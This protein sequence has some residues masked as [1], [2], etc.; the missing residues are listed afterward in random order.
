MQAPRERRAQRAEGERS[1]P[2]R[3]RR[4]RA[5][6]VAA[7][8]LVAWA[9]V[10]PPPAVAPTPPAQLPEPLR[11]L[12]HNHAPEELLV[13]ERPGSREF[14]VSLHAA[15][16]AVN[17]DRGPDRAP[18]ALTVLRWRRDRSALAGI[19]PGATPVERVPVDVRFDVW[20]QD[21]A[22]IA[23]AGE[24]AAGRLVLLD[25]RQR[26]DLARVVP[27]LA[28]RWGAAWVRLER[29]ANGTASGAGNVEALPG[30]LLLLGSTAGSRLAD[31]LFA[32]GY[33]ERHVRVDTSWLAIGHVDEIFSHVITGEGPCGFALLRASP[34]LGVALAREASVV[35][36]WLRR[37]LGAP[38]EA[39]H[40]VRV[41][42]A[43]DARIRAS[44]E[45]IRKSVAARLP[46]CAR[47]PVLALPVLFECQG[48]P[49]APRRC[50]PSLPNPVNLAVLDRHVLVP[51]P[52]W[53][54]FSDAIE[55]ALR[56]AGQ[57]P[58]LLDAG[59]YHRQLGGIHCATNVRRDPARLLEPSLGVGAGGYTAAP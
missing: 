8:A 46:A 49:E 43:L 51:D 38:D 29:D 52:G 50:R 9:C 32:H 16:E 47:L 3:Q 42:E 6:S 45:E 36:W 54:P 21:A 31:F 33:R 1:H 24:G 22:E 10:R 14:V 20:I 23:W 41:Q 44:V 37:R 40:Y 13:F 19:V 12:S 56:D 55:R 18:V 25:A 59:F 34:A 35:P 26:G 57:K 15:V 17:R 30:D 11:L 48:S 4:W 53:A 2:A 28:S 5:G 27:E 39:S 7:L 58:H